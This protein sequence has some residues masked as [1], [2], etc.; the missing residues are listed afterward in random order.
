MENCD[1]VRTWIPVHDLCIGKNNGRELRRWSELS[2][3]T[4]AM[5][6][7]ECWK[8]YA[9]IL[10]QYEESRLMNEDRRKVVVAVGVKVQVRSNLLPVPTI[11]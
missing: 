9:G 10:Y 11:G 1:W 3:A 4:I 7:E 6:R 2:H 8:A 5:L